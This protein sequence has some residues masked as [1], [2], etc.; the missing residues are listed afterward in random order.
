MR[1]HTDKAI[2]SYIYLQVNVP[3]SSRSAVYKKSV[4]KHY[5]ILVSDIHTDTQ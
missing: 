2:F 4:R 5:H 3:V 1:G